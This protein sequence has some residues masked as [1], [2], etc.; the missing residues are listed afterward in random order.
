M[1]ATDWSGGLTLRLVDLP[2]SEL[3][4]LKITVL[5]AVAWLLHRALAHANPRWRVLLWRGAAIAIVL[6]PVWM[7]FGP[8]VTISIAQQ[9]KAVEGQSAAA[10]DVRPPGPMVADFA[11]G[12]DFDR[13]KSPSGSHSSKPSTTATTPSVPA[14][15]GLEGMAVAK[16][17]DR[18]TVA[19]NRWASFW[20]VFLCVIWF[21]GFLLVAVRTIVGHWR[22]ARLLSTAAPAPDWILQI[23]S[24]VVRELPCRS[25]VDVVVS[26]R[27]QVPFLCGL[28][29]Q[30]IVVPY[31]FCDRKFE[32]DLPAIF[33]HELAHAQSHDVWW[34]TIVRIEAAAL[35]FHPLAWRIPQAHAASCED[36]GDAVSATYVGDARFYSRVLARVALELL[37]RPA[38]TAV[39]MA[40]TAEI[41]RRLDALER[42]VPH[43]PVRRWVLIA[44][45]FVCLAVVLG[46]ASLRLAFAV[47]TPGPA[48]VASPAPNAPAKKP[49]SQDATTAA[50]STRRNSEIL[51]RV[52]AAW[53]AR[54]ERFKTLHVTWKSRLLLTKGFEYQQPSQWPIAGMDPDEEQFKVANRFECQLAPSDLWGDEQGR[55]RD[56]LTVVRSHAL[57]EPKPVVRV[58][59][60]ADGT[61]HSRLVLPDS[62]EAPLMTIWREVP[63]PINTDGGMY[64]PQSAERRNRE[65]ELLP[66]MLLFR[67]Q[68]PAAG[69][70]PGACRVV[71]ENAIVDKVP[72]IKIRMES[73]Q[74]PLRQTR[75]D[76]RADNADTF[77]VDPNR[78]YVIVLWE[79]NWL[80][81]QPGTPLISVKIDYQRDDRFG[82]VPSHW[83]SRLKKGLR[84]TELAILDA[85][86][87][88]TALNEPLPRDTFAHAAPPR[89]RVYD[90]TIDADLTAKLAEESAKPAHLPDPSMSA[91]VAAWTRR[92]AKIRSFHFSWQKNWTVFYRYDDDRSHRPDVHSEFQDF[93]SNDAQWVDGP[94]SAVEQIVVE[95]PDHLFLMRTLKCAFD[96]E[97]TR[98]YYRQSNDEPGAGKTRKGFE[99][100][101]FPWSHGRPILIGLCP[102]SPKYSGINPS[103]CRV[104]PMTGKI[105][106]VDCT[107][108]HTEN[109]HSQHIFY[110]VDPA[111]DYLVLR[112]HTMSGGRD[113]AHIDFSYHLD[114][115]AGWVPDGWTQN[116]LSQYG[117]FVCSR[118]SKVS[119]YAVNE[120]LPASTFQIKFPSNVGKFD[121]L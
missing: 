44:T 4:L 97:S 45:A 85:S 53:N 90:V 73:S 40:R 61:T 21:I 105:G 56:D 118:T 95:S 71:E 65:T 102:A 19:T 72:C 34:N 121:S 55:L 101:H 48:S 42:T 36:V 76:R 24:R 27:A 6:G 79:R 83:E 41:S 68:S 70:V 94:R 112:E 17:D 43:R 103:L 39:A 12:A 69:L 37:S 74:P 109:G 49:G 91:I 25:R 54:Q 107:I 75:R 38:T 10:P 98:T 99:P 32:E 26:S 60:V 58:L 86:V 110:W 59:T 8:P 104:L 81:S 57:K 114:S 106:D 78:D 1:R 18:P 7:R 120:P 80:L 62:N 50:D 77:W 5:L 66:L 30:R 87:T 23:G 35:W 82:W 16:G 67:P 33:A 13:F 52:F 115:T 89:T 29:R 64:A 22:V 11:D 14:K 15:A 108:L 119:Q 117:C 3:V 46:A 96:G 28:W 93:R 92:Q 20:T 63:F 31:K 111:R 113:I 84:G 100:R 9:P 47:S 2:F 51:D 88:H 116:E